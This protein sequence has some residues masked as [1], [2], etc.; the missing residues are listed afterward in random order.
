MILNSEMLLTISSMRDS[1]RSKGAF[2]VQQ[3]TAIEHQNGKYSVQD[4]I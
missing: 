4:K 1:I 2:S 3:V